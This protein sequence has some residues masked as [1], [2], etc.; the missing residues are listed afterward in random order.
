MQER[1]AHLATWPRVYPSSQQSYAL[2]RQ[3]RG[4]DESSGKFSNAVCDISPT[5]N[6]NEAEVFASVSP[7]CNG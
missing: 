3:E 5:L 2:R 1:N 4:S 6:P 7:F